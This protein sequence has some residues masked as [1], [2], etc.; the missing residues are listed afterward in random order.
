MKW[1]PTWILLAL[2]V[3]L[4]AFIHFV[5]RKQRSP[6]AGGTPPAVLSIRSADVTAIQIRRTNQLILRVDRT[7]QTWSLT[8]P[9][10]YAK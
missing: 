6:G 7:N 3:A 8:T 10:F 4:F 5:E 9:L 2:A 1:K